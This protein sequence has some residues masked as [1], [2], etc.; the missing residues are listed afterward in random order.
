LQRLATILAEASLDELIVSGQSF[1]YITLPEK[2]RLR[3]Q[4]IQNLEAIGVPQSNII[5]AQTLWIIDLCMG[6]RDDITRL[7]KKLLPNVDV[8]KEMKLLPNDYNRQ[9]LP[10]PDALRKWVASKGINDKEINE[11]LDEY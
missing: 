4:I 11:L 8:D 10:L 7:A 9:A 2:F 3:D 6:F 5:N 1:Q